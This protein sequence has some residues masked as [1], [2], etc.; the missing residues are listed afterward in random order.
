MVTSALLT[1]PLQPVADGTGEKVLAEAAVTTRSETF[2]Q[3]RPVTEEQLVG[4]G[5]HF[6][7]WRA[8]N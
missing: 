4:H 6:A 5:I 1:A 8:G 3:R 2:C 7:P